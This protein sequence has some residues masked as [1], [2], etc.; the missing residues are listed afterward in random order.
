MVA[1]Y[2]RITKGVMGS[3]ANRDP[4]IRLMRGAKTAVE[5]KYGM[6]GLPKGAG[7]TR[8]PITLPPTPWDKPK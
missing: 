5:Y 1:G 8:K 2:K 6:G 4:K 3:G 7:H